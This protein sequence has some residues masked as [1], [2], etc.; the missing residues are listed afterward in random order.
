VLVAG[1]TNLMERALAET[2]DDNTLDPNAKLEFGAG[3]HAFDLFLNAVS[4]RGPMTDSFLDATIKDYV[5]QCYP[6]ARVSPAYGVDDDQLFRTTTDL[7]AAFAAMAGP[8]TFSTVYTA[9]DKAGSTVSCAQ[10]WEHISSRLSEPALFDDYSAQVCQRTGYD[11]ANAGQLARCRSNL[12]EMGQMMLATPLTAQAFLTDILLGNSVG[13]VLFEDSPA[14]AARVMA[15]R[16][17]VSNGLATMSTA[18]EWMP[19]IRATVFGIMLFMMPIALLFIL[20]P[21]NLRVASFALGLFVFVALWGVIDAGYFKPQITADDMTSDIQTLFLERSAYAGVF[22]PG[23]RIGIGV[24]HADKNWVVRAGLFGEKESAALD[25]D[26]DEAWLLS[27]RAHADL[28]PGPDVL[29]VAVESY[30]TK[31]SDTDHLVSLSQ[32][33]ET[34]RA[35]VIV[36]TGTFEADHGMFGGAELALAHGP[37][38]VQV[39]GGILDYHG[40]IVGPRFRGY[41]AQ[42][43]W[44]VTGEIRPYDSRAGTFGRV[45]PARPL[46]D[47]GWG[48]LEAGWRF[49]HVDLTD[50]GLQGGE[51]QTYGVVINWYPVTRVR[52]SANLI[53]SDVKR[54]SDHTHNNLLSFRGAVDW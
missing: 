30:Y 21:I 44:R 7:P 36:D 12:G 53:H 25:I 16:A 15:N 39:E 35:P 37:F 18:N 20:T 26:R 43:A 48:A 27:V 40:P 3:G 51:L 54:N 32:R 23:R 50:D 5:R 6:V 13:D 52:V 22:A 41:S 38:S 47:G 10:A 8:A 19:T 14:T 9:S 34:N 1:V 31:P 29:H 11:I 2:I 49:T 45:T 42:A 24:N 46:S 17:V 4:P 28:L 33:P